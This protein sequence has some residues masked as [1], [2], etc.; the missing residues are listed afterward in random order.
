MLQTNPVE[1]TFV[2]RIRLPDSGTEWDDNFHWSEEDSEWRR[3]TA[4]ARAE[5]AVAVA[6]SAMAK[7]V[8]NHTVS[9]QAEALHATL[10]DGGLR[11]QPE[12]LHATLRDGGLRWLARRQANEETAAVTAAAARVEVAAATQAAM[13]TL[14]AAQNTA[15]G[16]R[17]KYVALGAAQAAMQTLLAAQNAAPGMVPGMV[18]P[19]QVM[20]VVVPHGVVEG[21]QFRAFTPSGFMVVTCPPG[22]HAGDKVK[23]SVHSQAAGRTQPGPTGSVSLPAPA[24]DLTLSALPMPQPGLIP[25]PLPPPPIWVAP[26][27][28]MLPLQGTMLL[29]PTHTTCWDPSMT[30]THPVTAAHPFFGSACQAPPIEAPHLSVC[31][32]GQMPLF[33]S[34]EPR[35]PTSA[36]PNNCGQ[37]RFR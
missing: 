33:A 2:A 19:P 37:M 36:L 20:E 32:G 12:A 30:P 4:T 27:N 22:A 31:G 28:N 14:Q 16:T 10:Q 1:R 35:G 17:G 26:M 8:A 24:P 29:P 9:M 18:P 6:Q 13:Q 3:S 15:P 23:F 25:A 21:Q 34:A 11:M 7:S 5:A